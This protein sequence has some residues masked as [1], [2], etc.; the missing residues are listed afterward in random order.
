MALIDVLLSPLR[1]R[2]I[3][4]VSDGEPFTTAELGKRFPD[5]SKATIYRQV[6]VLGEHG[7][8]EI[9]GEE[10]KRGGTE[11]TYRLKSGSAAMDPGAM[12]ALTADQH[13]ELFTAAMGGL[14]AE[15]AF[16]LTSED[17]DP[18]ADAVSYRQFSLW[19]SDKEKTQL[20]ETIAAALKSVWANKPG[21]D[22]RRH[23]LSTIL[24][25][26]D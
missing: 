9:V 24:F 13:R 26:T 22:R 2:L 11:R 1:L 20:V 19:L 6:A 10:R 18:Y 12:A 8:L 14:I 4:A 23:V 5:V 15:F 3:H 21:D 25:P 7:L 16:Y 17:A